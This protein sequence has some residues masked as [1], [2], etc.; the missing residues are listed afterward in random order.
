M[1]DGCVQSLQTVRITAPDY[2]R[3]G[4]PLWLNCSCDLQLQQIYSIKWFKDNQEFYRFIVSEANPK[5]WYNTSGVYPDPV[6][7]NKG[8]IYM[9]S[10]DFQTQGSYRCEISEETGFQTLHEVKDIRVYCK[11]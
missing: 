6:K 7:S 3:F 4:D 10:T 11:Q 9:T 2:V 8:D 5:T 1:S